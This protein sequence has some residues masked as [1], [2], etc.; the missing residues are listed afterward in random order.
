M[1]LNHFVKLNVLT[2]VKNIVIIKFRILLLDFLIILVL[3]SVII[4]FPN[5]SI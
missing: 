3:V 4:D 5:A 1:K 2:S